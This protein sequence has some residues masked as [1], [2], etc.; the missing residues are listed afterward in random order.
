[1]SCM[2]EFIKLGINVLSPYG[3]CERYDFVFEYKGTFYK[4][5]V[6]TSKGDVDAFHFSAKS[7]TKVKGKTMHRHYTK[8]ETDFFA[9]FYNNKCYLIPINEIGGSKKLRINTPANGQI[10]NISFAKNYELDVTLGKL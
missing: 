10:E 8:E 6:K 7:N 4:V 2:L 1:M 5:Q 9:T 3:D